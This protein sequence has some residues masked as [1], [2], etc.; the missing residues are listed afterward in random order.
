MDIK[1]KNWLSTQPKA[2]VYDKE[3]TQGGVKRENKFESYVIKNEEV[4]PIINEL[5]EEIYRLTRYVEKELERIGELKPLTKIMV[6]MKEQG[7]KQEQI[8]ESTRYSVRQVQRILKNF[9]N[10]RNIG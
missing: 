1:Y 4:D 5:K 6:E 2:M 9:Y 7:K 10:K 3:A 8:A